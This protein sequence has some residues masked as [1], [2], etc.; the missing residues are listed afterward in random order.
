M[1]RLVCVA[2]VLSMVLCWV[3]GFA[4]GSEKLEIDLK[5]AS[6]EEI[7]NAVKILQAELKSR[8]QTKIVLNTQEA[9]VPKG[10][11][12]ELS[13]SI[14]DLPDDAEA[15]AF[16]WKS[17]DETVAG[18][19]NG[20]VTGKNVGKAVVTCSAVLS[21]GTELYE[22]CA[23][24]VIV[25]IKSLKIK[26]S[27]IELGPKSTA[28]IETEVKPKDA[29][30]L[31]FE[32]ESSDPAI[33]SVDENGV[34][35]GVDIGKAE[36]KVKAADGSGQ[37]AIASV[38][39]KSELEQQEILFL[40]IPW[41]I[42]FEDV[43]NALIEKGIIEKKASSNS[44]VYV[45]P[46]NDAVAAEYYD[47]AVLHK[48]E[49]YRAIKGN[50]YASSLQA[51]PLKLIGG[52]KA[53]HCTFSFYYGV[54][55]DGT[56]N[57]DESHLFSVWIDASANKA[58]TD[59]LVETLTLKYGKP[60]KQEAKRHY[61]AYIWEG[62]NNTKLMVFTLRDMARDI[63]FVNTGIS[64]LAKSMIEAHKPAEKPLDDAGI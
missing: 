31:K 48:T 58:N 20:L 1:K 9:L 10:G 3:S 27:K 30:I 53:S 45:Y 51:R 57:K 34:V 16:V 50:G 61:G 25:P 23:V 59:K 43:N 11:K 56:A 41:D 28:S 33:A 24:E 29:S 7:R 15:G 60:K 62:L 13:A 39:V 21:D 18:V 6:D 36:I 5:S 49:A 46:G 63:F 12:L 40:D 55:A 37:E 35:T 52:L 17:S 32:Y 47:S 8:M 38:A 42:S 26:N 54:N 4:E 19:K 64:D 2:V 22:E 14:E 44:K